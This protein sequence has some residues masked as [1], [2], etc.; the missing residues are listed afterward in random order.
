MAANINI[1]AL[2]SAL[3]KVRE[4]KGWSW[5]R[6]AQDTGITQ[7]TFTRLKKGKGVSAAKVF[8]LAKWSGADANKFLCMDAK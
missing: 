2:Y 6:V 8:T 7:S 1:H 3:D 4:A 5:Y